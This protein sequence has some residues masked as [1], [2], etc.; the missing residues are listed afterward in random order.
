MLEQFS[1]L[2]DALVEQ[3]GLRDMTAGNVVMIAVGATLVYLA[4]AK[5]YEPFLLLGIGFACIVSNVPGSDLTRP[6]GLFYFAYQGVALVIVPP[7]IFL[8]IGAMTDFGPMIARPGLMVLG[9]AAHAGIFIAIILAKMLGFS[10]AK[11]ARSAS[12]A[13]PTARWP[14]S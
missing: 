11:R 13:A 2:L 14:S 10:I 6:G 9:A 8:G 7:L 3:T 1:G 4:L 5:K 12:S